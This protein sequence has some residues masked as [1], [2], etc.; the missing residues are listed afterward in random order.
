MSL[1]IDLSD[2]SMDDDSSVTVNGIY[3]L[4]CVH[5]KI[6]NEENP[7]EVLDKEVDQN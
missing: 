3:G 2:L 4:K 7:Q 6:R 5:S 1:G